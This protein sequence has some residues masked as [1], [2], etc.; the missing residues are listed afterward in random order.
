MP[1]GPRD[2]PAAAGDRDN[3]TGAG[4]NRGQADGD[5]NWRGSATVVSR[6]AE[7]DQP[8]GTDDRRAATGA[9]RGQADGDRDWRGS[10]AAVTR[11]EE[12]PMRSEEMAPATGPARSL[13]AGANRGQAD[14]DTNWRGSANAVTRPETPPA[15]PAP[16]EASWRGS[17]P[18]ASDRT[19]SW[20]RGAAFERPSFDQPASGVGGGFDR[21]ERPGLERPGFERPASGV[22]HGAHFGGRAGPPPCSFFLQGRCQRGDACRFS[23][24]LPEGQEAPTQQP[25]AGRP[26]S[27]KWERG[28]VNSPP[29]TPVVTPQ[30]ANELRAERQWERKPLQLQKP[31][32]SHAE[33]VKAVADEDGFAVVTKP[34]RAMGSR[35]RAAFGRS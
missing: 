19:A 25:P 16:S 3:R 6:P 4:A 5:I 30:K 17:A 26:D 32:R 27:L 24:V 21:F 31:T 29:S 23:H 28:A 11:P 33:P 9:N 1:A 2:E 34:K 8:P 13:G 7:V 15:R 18:G 10:A 35:E 22:G 14:G 20:E 12:P